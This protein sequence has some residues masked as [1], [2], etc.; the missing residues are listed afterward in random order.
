[1]VFFLG[2]K[3]GC[4]RCLLG[5][6]SV[7]LAASVRAQSGQVRHRAP[8]AK[9][10][11]HMFTTYTRVAGPS[12]AMRSATLESQDGT[13]CR[14]IMPVEVFFVHD[15]R[16]SREAVGEVVK[17]ESTVAFHALEGDVDSFVTKSL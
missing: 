13:A 17:C 7:L 4:S 14:Q 12:P 1:M 16:L 5:M 6:P 15:T 11:M 9:Q 3:L 2:W 10:F 8:T